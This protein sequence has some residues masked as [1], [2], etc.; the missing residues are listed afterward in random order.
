MANCPHCGAPFPPGASYC[1]SCGQPL[2][3][4]A[5]GAAKSDRTLKTIVTIA[6][7][8][9][10][11][12][13]LLFVGGIVAA[14][15]IPNFVDAL[16]KAKQKRTVAELRTLAVALESYREQSGGYPPAGAEVGAVLAAHGYQGKAQDGWDRPLRYSC[17]DSSGDACASYELASGGKDGVFEQ[18]PGAYSQEPFAPNLYDSDLVL[19]DGLFSRWPE[20]QGRSPSSG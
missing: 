18:E 1:A 3:V 15:V 4:A 16:Q 20:G 13:A 9:G 17:L 12:L 5:A 6:I 10:C 7:A 19:S 14:L 2:A 11:L 8:G